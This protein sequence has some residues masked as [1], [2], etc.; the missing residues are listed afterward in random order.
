MPR[1][2]PA[3]PNLDHLKHEAKAI[4]TAVNDGDPD[5]TRRAHDQIGNWSSFKLTDAQRV[6]AREYGFPTWARLRAHVLAARGDDAALNALLSAVS[7]HDI[8][9]A[10]TVLAAHPGLETRSAHAAAALGAADDLRRLL[11]ADGARADARAGD[12]PGEP[13]FFLCLSPFHGESAARDAGLLDAARLLLSAGADPNARG[14]AFNLPP[15]YGVTALRSVLPLA[16][17]LLDAGANPTDGE[18]LFHAAEHD[19]EDALQL[20]LEA[21]ADLNGSGDWGNTPLYFL[22]RWWDV[23]REPR[24]HRGILWLLAHGADPNVTCGAERE[25]ALHAA[26]RRGQSV[27]VVRALI[28]HGADVRAA[29]GDGRTAWWLAHRGGFDALAAL[30]VDA[31]AVPEPLSPV[32]ELISACGRGDRA[33]ARRLAT[34]ELLGTLQPADRALVPEAAAS[35]RTET[36]RAFVDAGFPVDATDTDGATALHHAALR[37]NAALVRALVEA[38]AALDLRDRVHHSTP[39]GWATFG[40]DH[41]AASG[42]EYERTV[43]ALL[44]AGARPRPDEYRP[45]NAGVRAAIERS[46]GP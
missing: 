46:V 33:A 42:G 23:E 13:L 2:L 34:P 35:G 40:A 27:P 17:L 5:A 16:R 39:M 18:S 30:L 1:T 29:R 28:E 7:D 11:S 32:D 22:L 41:V 36:V 44:A 3:R 14:G 31:G 45:E 6:I 37:G 19:R 12:P 43:E 21:G 4:R 20:L 15:L 38:G 8:G 25:N 10:R 9:R 26:V 24:V